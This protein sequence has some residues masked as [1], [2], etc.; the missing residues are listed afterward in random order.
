MIYT[1]IKK[2]S[3]FTSSLA[4]ISIDDGVRVCSSFLIK[5]IYFIDLIVPFMY[6]V[7][8]VFFIGLSHCA[9]NRCSVLMALGSVF[10]ADISLLMRQFSRY[11]YATDIDT[12]L[13]FSSMCPGS[14]RPCV[15]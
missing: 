5:L 6:C 1:I 4:I 13:D 11:S 9:L 8:C 10:Q 2:L 12:G 14:T 3:M 15:R 7:Y